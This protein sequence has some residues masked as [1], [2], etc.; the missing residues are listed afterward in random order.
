VC[1]ICMTV[2]LSSNGIGQFIFPSPQPDQGVTVFP[3]EG[4]LHYAIVC[5]PGCS[6]LSLL[7]IE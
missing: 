3:L 4:K 6:P 7:Q 1:F 2:I 5:G